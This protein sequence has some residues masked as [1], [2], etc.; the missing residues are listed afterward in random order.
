MAYKYYNGQSNFFFNN[1]QS[2]QEQDL[3]ESLII[4]SIA[5]YGLDCFYIPRKLNNYDEVYG[6]DDQSSY[7]N[8]YS[9]VCYIENINGFQG[10]GNFMSK[11]GL[12]IRDQIVVAVAQ[13]IFNQEVGQFTTQTRPNEGDLLYFP[14]NKK[15][16][17]VKYTNK[18]EFFYQLGGLQTYQ[19]TLELFEYAGEKLN[20]GIPE[21]DI[22]QKNFDSNQFS[23]AIRVQ[24]G[25]FI[26]TEDGELLVLEGSS[27]EDL[28][29]SADN[30]EIQRESDLFVDFTAQ[31]PF[32]DGKI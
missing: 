19:L 18:H 28:Y 13:R 27:I 21:I 5:I 30:D 16:F 7:E 8:S 1:F 29:P 4:E 32:S 17:Q 12:E 15:C 10:D 11:F 24:N 3:L 6:A 26:L 20:T 31:D 2:S 9:I 22:L 25:D 14:L 23:W